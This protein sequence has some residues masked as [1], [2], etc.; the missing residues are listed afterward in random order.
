M[1]RKDCG[2]FVC[3]FAASY[4]AQKHVI[5]MIMGEEDQSESMN[6]VEKV[7]VTL[8]TQTQEAVQAFG[9]EWR[10][11]MAQTFR[12]GGTCD[13]GQEETVAG[14]LLKDL[15]VELNKEDQDNDVT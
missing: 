11:V 5:D 7:D 4:M 14:R 1:G 8:P 9:Q 6:A 10:Y 2:I 12:D 3:A 15:K 13:F